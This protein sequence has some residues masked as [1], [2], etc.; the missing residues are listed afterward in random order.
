LNPSMS[1]LIRWVVAAALLMSACAGKH[2]DSESMTGPGVGG[3]GEDGAGAAAGG[4]DGTEGGAT[5]GGGG[6]SPTCHVESKGACTYEYCQ[7]YGLFWEPAPLEEPREDVS[8]VFA[9]DLT[10]TSNVNRGF[11]LSSAADPLASL[12]LPAGTEPVH[13]A[14]GFFAVG[15][16]IEIASDDSQQPALETRVLV[17]PR[18]EL[19]L[20]EAPAHWGIEYEGSTGAGG[21]GGTAGGEGGAAG[22]GDVGAGGDIAS[23]PVSTL[24]PVLEWEPL[25]QGEL[26]LHYRSRSSPDLRFSLVAIRCSVP[27]SVGRLELPPEEREYQGTVDVRGAAYAVTRSAEGV[28][29]AVVARRPLL[30]WQTV[31]E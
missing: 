29:P 26:V 14:A 24:Q 10:V 20:L 18:P 22:G 15:D 8:L 9:A 1:H 3:E 21:E 16:T 12:L 17:P 5:S 27:L 4:I 6:T 19:R 30:S 23:A 28:L 25:A 31:G 11:K 2:L 13:Q 7:G